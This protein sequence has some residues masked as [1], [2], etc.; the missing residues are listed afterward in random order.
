MPFNV[1]IVGDDG[2]KMCS[3]FKEFI[4]GRGIMYAPH[5]R[6]PAF[7]CVQAHDRTALP[8]PGS[9]HVSVVQASKL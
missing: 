4:Y 2:M 9:S 6:F 8:W 1:S 3:S 5:Q 7:P